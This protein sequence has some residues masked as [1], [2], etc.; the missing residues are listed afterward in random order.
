M[1]HIVDTECQQGICSLNFVVKDFSGLF[2]H[3]SI[4]SIKDSRSGMNNGWHYN[5]TKIFIFT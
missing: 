1:P 3:P 5:S 4:F 2:A